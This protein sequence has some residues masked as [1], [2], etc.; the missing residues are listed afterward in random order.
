MSVSKVKAASDLTTGAAAVAN[1]EV[2][3][4]P[5]ECSFKVV[6]SDGDN[7]FFL[8]VRPSD[9]DKICSRWIRRSGYKVLD[10]CRLYKP[11]HFSMQTP[12]MSTLRYRLADEDTK[13]L[14]A[15]DGDPLNLNAIDF[16][17]NQV[18]A[19]V[20]NLCVGLMCFNGRDETNIASIYVFNEYRR[21]GY[22]RAMV[23]DVESC[24]SEIHCKLPTPPA[25]SDSIQEPDFWRAIGWQV[26]T[27]ADTIY[28]VGQ[29]RPPPV[30]DDEFERLGTLLF[31]MTA[32]LDSELKVVEFK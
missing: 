3:D 21:R 15:N 26:A 2:S 7:A 23:N 5:F 6:Q 28:G 27:G 20:G 19:F 24:V 16:D 25:S 18:G 29:R 12:T 31:A 9:L 14:L 11:L 32:K 22:G 13:L 4:F 30:S 1:V 8:V 17:V 10:E